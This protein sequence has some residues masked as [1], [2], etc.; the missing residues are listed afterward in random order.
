MSQAED[1]ASLVS[2]PVLSLPNGNTLLPP[3]R[4]E[5]I[6]AWSLVSFTVKTS[7]PNPQ[8]SMH[9]LVTI[10]CWVTSVI[11]LDRERKEKKRKKPWLL[12]PLDDQS[13][14]H[15]VL[16]PLRLLSS[17]SSSFSP[18]SPISTLLNLIDFSFLFARSL[19]S[20]R[21]NWILMGSPDKQSPA[22]YRS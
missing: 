4:K 21:W 6:G 15:I 11:P 7:V 13:L 10:W 1:L 8:A 18:L 2:G 16:R 17:P 14:Q 9:I 22:V 19:L 5:S 20:L 3:Q 12:Q